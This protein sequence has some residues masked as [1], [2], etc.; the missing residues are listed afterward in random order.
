ME[1]Q[2]P[3]GPPVP[4]GRRVLRVPRAPLV[5]MVR[6]VPRVPRVPP[7]V[8]GLELVT[9]TSATNSTS[10]KTQ[11][12]SCTGGKRV[13]GGGGG[14]SGSAN[15]A[16]K[17]SQPIGGPPPTGWSVTG[18]ETDVLGLGNWSVTA[19]VICATVS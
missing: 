18:V 12:V 13:L 14:V 9:A 8:S 1:P 10:P 16:I 7:G 6:E 19:Y 2:A 15:P 17:A 3:R 5:P 11:V 4:L